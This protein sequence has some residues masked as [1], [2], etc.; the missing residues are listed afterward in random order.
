M[1]DNALIRVENMKTYFD[2]DE[3]EL[4]AVDGV[5]FH[6]E[7]GEVFA[8]VGESGCGKSVTAYTIM[9]ILPCPPGRIAAGRVLFEG[10]DLLRYSEKQMQRVRGAQISMIFQEPMTSLNPVFTCGAQISEAI[11]LHRR[12]GAKAAKA[13]AID[14]LARVGI[15]EPRQCHD[16]Y[17]HQLSGGMR[18]RVM[19]AAALSCRPRMLIAD[20]P[21]TALDV[22]TQAQI[23]SLIRT[24]QAQQN[25]SVLL[26]THDLGVV[27]ETADRVAVM[28][29]SKVVETA[30]TQMLFKAPLHPYTQGLF[31]AV[32]RLGRH[33]ERLPAIAGTVPRP[34]QFPSGCKFHTRCPLTR[35]KARQGRE[36]QQIITESGPTKVLT[37]CASAEPPLQRIHTGHQCACWEAPGY[38]AE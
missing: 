23:L 21:T 5:D 33:H 2:T 24:L 4:R 8:L 15:T 20:E 11:R 38:A 10:K 27:A 35:E 19:I 18:Q 17:P 13:E 32:P 14:M 28:Y 1:N 6:I 26:I 12:L 16:A 36:T 7:P 3:G 31:D 9:K 34:W 25:M 37:R 30:E 22:T 29:A